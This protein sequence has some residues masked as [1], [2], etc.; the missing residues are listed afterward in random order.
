LVAERLY[1]ETLSSSLAAAEYLTS[2]SGKSTKAVWEC[3]EGA[4][5]VGIG[6]MDDRID[7]EE[8]VDL[9]LDVGTGASDCKKAWDTARKSKVA[10]KAKL[11]TYANLS[12]W[13]HVASDVNQI[14]DDITSL[15]KLC[16]VL[17]RFCP[18]G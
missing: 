16:G 14:S 2:G 15:T 3:T 8:L 9:A 11:P 12:K 10:K 6:L 18:V 7:G 17:G 5:E 4:A 13:L 1:E